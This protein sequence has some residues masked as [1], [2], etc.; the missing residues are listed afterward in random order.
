MIQSKC[1]P[2]LVQESE[3]LVQ[4]V[5]MKV[6]TLERERGP[7]H[8]LPRA[9]IEKIAFSRLVDEIR[10]RRVRRAE[11]LSEEETASEVPDSGP[12]PQRATD[13][14]A[15]G[16]AIL[17]CLKKIIEPRRIA[18]SLRLRG[19][20]PAEIAGGMGWNDRRAQNLV[21]R[22]MEDLRRCLRDKGMNP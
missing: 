10:R 7:D 21:F 9:Y 19:Y 18:V 3:D 4:E 15:A 16:E 14:A 22:G 11:S 5:L 13:S 20:S 6:I 2:W 12:D 8:P 1:S 17:D